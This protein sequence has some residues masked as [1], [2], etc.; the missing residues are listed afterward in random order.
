M[1]RPI[2]FIRR[3]IIKKIRKHLEEGNLIGVS[4]KMSGIRSE[5]TLE[6]WKDKSN[7]NR[8]GRLIEA[9][10]QRGQDVRD[11]AVE[12]AQYKRLIEGKAS[13]FEYQFYLTNRRTARW[14]KITEFGST[15]GA[16]I[17]LKPPVINYISVSVTHGAKEVIQE[18]NN[19]NG[20]GR[21]IEHV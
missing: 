13:G 14:K 16:P 2:M 6:A 11:D 21:H 15:Q 19:G 20:N 9:A 3:E 18:N 8:L 10:R 5:Q 7:F 4:R 1:E 17:L 12:D